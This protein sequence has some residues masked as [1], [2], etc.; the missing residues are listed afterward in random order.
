M[1]KIM[2]ACL[3][4]YDT[5]KND[6]ESASIIEMIDG[7]EGDHEIKK[8]IQDAVKRLEVVNPAVAREIKVKTR[9]FAF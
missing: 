6:K 9:G 2:D 7:V 8:G 3:L 5:L 1:Q 4:I